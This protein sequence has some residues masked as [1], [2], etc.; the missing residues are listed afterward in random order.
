MSMTEKQEAGLGAAAP[1]P[2]THKRPV[3]PRDM[4]GRDPLRDAMRAKTR[5]SDEEILRMFEREETNPFEI[6]ERIKPEGYEYVWKCH[7]V[8]GNAGRFNPAELQKRGFM[9]VMAEDHPGYFKPTGH[10]GHVIRDGLGLYKLEKY[11]HDNR[12][13]YDGIIAR[14]QVQDQEQV[15]GIAPP[16]QGP[17]DHPKLRPSIRTNYEAVDVE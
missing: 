11:N 8:Y 14:R 3:P 1:P 9:Q 17:R 4:V 2:V 6:D 5:L 7:E 13:R 15:L 12:V 10:T 16:G